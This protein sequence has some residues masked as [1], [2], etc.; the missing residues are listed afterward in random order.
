MQAFGLALA[1]ATSSALP[2]ILGAIGSL[3]VADL[4]MSRSQLGLL[5]STFYLAASVCSVI[6]GRLVDQT[7]WKLQFT[8]LAGLAIA[9][10]GIIASSRSFE[11]LL[12]G[13]IFNGAALSLGNPVTNAYIAVGVQ[14]RSVGFVTG[15]KQSGVQVGALV[16]GGLVPTV[17]SHA[18]WRIG[19][20]ISLILPLLMA[21]IL[22]CLSFLAAHGPA[23]QL[24]IVKR[25]TTSSH[26]VRVTSVAAY[27]ALLGSGLGSIIVYLPLFAV[28]VMAVS[29]R[30]AAATIAVVGAAGFTSRILLGLAVDNSAN[31]RHMLLGIALISCA[32]I[33]ILPLALRWPPILWLVACA[34]GAGAFS[35]MAVG[36]LA[37]VHMATNGGV[38]RSSAFISLWFY[39]GFVVGAPIFGLTVDRSGHYWFGWGLVFLSFGLAA[40][41]IG[42]SGQAPPSPRV[43][44]ASD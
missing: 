33:A 24:K 30:A 25:A 6:S 16:A 41:V 15:I 26:H 43:R 5:V 32:A 23:D 28:E 37:A 40:V 9:G 3:I 11:F 42:R 12:L 1:M 36:M 2:F 13:V 4:G 8:L 27:G 31:I 21:L 20:L 18:G 14:P 34:L 38:G 19:I 10:T 7:S 39:V 22:A 17:A 35:W 29:P 44:P